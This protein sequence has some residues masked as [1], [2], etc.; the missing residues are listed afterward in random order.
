M[1]RCQCF[2]VFRERPAWY[3]AFERK[4]VCKIPA[5]LSI[6]GVTTASS[7]DGDDLPMPHM[8]YIRTGAQTAYVD[9]LMI[10]A[11]RPDY[12]LSR[13]PENRPGYAGV[14][15]RVSGSAPTRPRDASGKPIRGYVLVGSIV[16]A[17]GQLVA[18]RAL[19]YTDPRLAEA[20]RKSAE[21]T[22]VEPARMGERP[23]AEALWQQFEF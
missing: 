16:N 9:E 21:E 20:A 13:L 5:G 2:K 19:L 3:L 22:R 8:A 11:Y 6:A 14:G 23:V 1:T 15:Q 18:N 17:Q 12:V 10:D 4:P 7:G